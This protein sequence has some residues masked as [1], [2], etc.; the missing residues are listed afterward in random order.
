[1]HLTAIKRTKA[2]NTIGFFAVSG[3]R[4]GLS[5]FAGNMDGENYESGPQRR[6]YSRFLRHAILELGLISMETS[7]ES[8]EQHS[9]NRGWGG[10]RAGAGRRPREADKWI[11]ARGLSPA[12]AAELLERSDE[13]RIWYRLLNST[14]DSIVL[15]A[16]MYLTDRRDGRPAQQINLTSTNLTIDARDIER[17]RA[18]VRE[19]QG[20]PIALP[21]RTS[22]Q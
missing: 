15:R 12:T 2:L 4:L 3:Q 11:R 20:E 7:A 10:K 14:D 22:E 9:R 18:I 19:M 21:A 8:R 1:L 13:R 6:T 5:N 16:A 17:A